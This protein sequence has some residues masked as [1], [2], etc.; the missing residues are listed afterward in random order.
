M[1]SGVKIS[2]Q[3]LLNIP[4]LSL[5]EL[6]APT[7]SEINIGIDSTLVTTT[8]EARNRFSPVDRQCYFDDEIHLHYL[9][10]KRGGNLHYKYDMSNCLVE[11]M[12]QEIHSKCKCLPAM[13]ADVGYPV[14]S[15]KALK[16]SEDLKSEVKGE[17]LDEQFST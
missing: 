9:S 15:G 6:K 7:G 2:I 13:L 10:R 8:P 5:N 3:G 4:L 1:P 11:A 12:I 16:C 14:C 17:L